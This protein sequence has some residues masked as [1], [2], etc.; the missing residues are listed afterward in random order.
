M[1]W[2]GSRLHG[3][4]G[5]A[6]IERR[7]AILFAHFG[8]TGPAILD[9]SRAV[10]RHEGTEPLDLL[11]DF[12]PD[13][14]SDTIDQAA[15]GSLQVRAPPI[16]SVLPG[17]LPLPLPRRLAEALIHAAGIPRARVGPELSRDERGRLVAR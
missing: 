7:E 11:I 17:L 12:A 16:A 1:Y 10:A 2:P 15:P 5:P 14:R 13:E 9:V 4:S 8:L 6:L 3:K